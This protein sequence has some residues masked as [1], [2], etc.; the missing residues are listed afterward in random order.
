MNFNTKC[1]AFNVQPF[2]R[3]TSLDS[4]DMEYFEGLNSGGCQFKFDFYYS[5]YLYKYDKWQAYKNNLGYYAIFD[6]KYSPK[7]LSIKTHKYIKL[8]AG[9]NPIGN[10]DIIFDDYYGNA[11]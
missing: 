5:K 11:L 9:K 4:K 10:Y 2:K 7:T 3:G 6:S 8:L 1:I